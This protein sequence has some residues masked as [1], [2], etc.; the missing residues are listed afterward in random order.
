MVITRATVIV[1]VT[2]L[3]MLRRIE[4]IF[5]KGMK[6]QIV[7]IMGKQEYRGG[8]EY[9]PVTYLKKCEVEHGTLIENTMTT[10]I[11][12]LE[13]GENQDDAIIKEKL[14]ENWYMIPAGVSE[15]SIFYAVINS[16]RSRYKRTDGVINGF[17]IFTTTACNARC[18]YCYEAGIRQRSMSK[19]MA[20][21]VAKYIAS[22]RG[23]R[24]VSIGWF[25]G[26]PLC[27]TEAMDVISQYLADSG[28]TY[29]SSIIT[30]GYLLNRYTQD[31]ICNV[32]KL[33]HAQ[34][35]LDG[36]QEE[37]NRIKGY[38][39]NPDN[40]FE[41]VLSNIAM[42]ADIG[43]QVSI[44]LNLSAEN[45]DDLFALVPEIQERFSG[46]RYIGAYVHPLFDSAESDDIYTKYIEL[47]QAL[48]NAGLRNG[49]GIDSIRIQHCMAD[50]DGYVCITPEG[51]LTPCEHYCDTEI[52]GNIKTG[53]T[54]AVKVAEWKEAAEE[55]ECCASCWYYPKCCRLKKCPTEM[56]CTDGMRKFLEYQEDIVIKNTYTGYQS[57]LAYTQQE[58]STTSVNPQE[59]ISAALAAVGKTLSDHD[60]WSEIFP[61]RRNRGWC[62]P[63]LYS[64]FNAAYGEE[65]AHEVLYASGYTYMPH[66]HARQ[67]KSE[68]AWYDAPQ[69][70]DIAFFRGEWT[71]HA[72]LVTAV[73][74]G[75]IEVT[76]GNIAS[77]GDESSVQTLNFLV[78][79]ESIAGFG[80]PKWTF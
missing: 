40:A 11:V 36:T 29:T 48:R 53:I 33:R 39:D 64:V 60:Y 6:K 18:P 23:N 57:Q 47:D 45:Y 21:D 76:G 3:V 37:Y 54:D 32:W 66:V 78:D 77:E 72:A 62:M 17:T 15:R 70:G 55:S 13:T 41:Q 34:I 26:E 71:N 31:Q 9:V 59:V 38:V 14:V 43:I 65:T 42:L 27:N 67:F 80:R 30:N 24:S 49:P 28:T 20:L 52:I 44:R 75:E 5:V 46:S 79:D 69:V 2:D 68:N 4:V 73:N 58:K 63:F 74:D 51:N 1:V 25:G 7:E 50:N 10:Q 19:E 61:G 8:V 12:L 22:V 16:Y 56:K 35:T